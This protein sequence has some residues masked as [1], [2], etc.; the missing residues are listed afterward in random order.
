[1]KEIEQAK[2]ILERKIDHIQTVSDWAEFMNIES[3]KYFSRIIRNYYGKRPKK[4]I[5]E[6]KLQKIRN[7]FTTMDKEIFFAVAKTLGFK[8]DIALYKFVKRHTGK[9]LKEL[10]KECKKGV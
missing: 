2:D 3:K 1:M 9:T 10:R 6:I 4:I 5:V 8:S 7:V